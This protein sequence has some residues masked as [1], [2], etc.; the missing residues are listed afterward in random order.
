MPSNVTGEFANKSW[1]DI[2]A[3]ETAKQQRRESELLDEVVEVI[4]DVVEENK[5]VMEQEQDYVQVREVVQE[6]QEVQQ[7]VPQVQQVVNDLPILAILNY[8]LSQLL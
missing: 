8:N 1:A 3:E 6:V 2:D 7:V 4:D 5:K